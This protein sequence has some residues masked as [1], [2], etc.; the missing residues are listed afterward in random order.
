MGNGGRIRVLPPEVA[1]RIAAGAVIECPASA[2]K[3]LVENSPDPGARV[4][5]FLTSAASG[6]AHW[7]VLLAANNGYLDLG[8]ILNLRTWPK[9]R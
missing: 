5:F 2:V 1:H 9:P 3:E 8:D 6:R 7:S 4:F